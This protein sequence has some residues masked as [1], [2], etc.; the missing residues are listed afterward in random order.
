MSK[1]K[2]K[3]K[4]TAVTVTRRTVLSGA[5]AIGLS[6]VVR[7]A[8]P[9]AEVKVGLLVPI[10][11]MYAR[12]G[13]VMREGAEMAIDHINS[14][15]GVKA[16]GGAKLKLVVLDCGDTT[17]KAKSAAQR[18]VAQEPDLVAAS[19]AYLSSFT[20]AVTEVT[21]R[22][23]L[24]VLTLSY[25]DL[26]TDRGFKYV[27]QTSATAASQAKQAL[28]QIISLAQNASGK[29][30]KTVAIVTDNTGAS[31][32]S[33]KSMREGLLAA[34]GLQLV[35]DET[36]T[37]PLADATSL[38]QKVRSAKPDLLFF[39][40]TVISDA[41]LL[42]EKMNEFGMGQGKVPTI[43][44]GI[45][46]AEPD[47]LQTVSAEL[48]QGVLTCVASWGAKGHEALIAELK[49]RYNEPWMTQNAIS[50]Y[51]DMWVIKDALEKAGKADRIAVADALRTIDAGPSKY[52]PL[53]EIKFDEKGRRIGAGMTIVQWQTGVPVTVFPPE[54][55]LAQPIWPKS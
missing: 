46:I 10:S 47:M 19:A 18:M 38:V 8:E 2:S 26:I 28:P 13:A 42:L 36:F 24:P 9:Q 48:L 17:E 35:L 25:S 33:A 34:N 5:A 39:L 29:K 45:A 3:Y 11:G 14:Q 41:K 15:G 51:G 21:E 1:D 37:P 40:P 16:L 20:L 52:Y 32:A 4:G 23:N 27:F 50:T 55:A 53:G 54:L 22:A 44:F 6:G 7:A 43:S 49:K 30:P 12:P 31:V